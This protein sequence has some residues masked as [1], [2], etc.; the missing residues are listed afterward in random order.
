MAIAVLLGVYQLNT[1]GGMD[2]RTNLNQLMQDSVGI[3]VYG[4]R[5]ITAEELALM[6]DATTGA[7]ATVDLLLEAVK[8]LRCQSLKALRKALLFLQCAIAAEA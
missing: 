8:C 2:Y 7:P 6:L 4:H 1:A 3:V 5:V